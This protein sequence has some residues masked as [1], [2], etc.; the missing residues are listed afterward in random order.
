MS[1][2]KITRPLAAASLACVLILSGCGAATHTVWR[3]QSTSPDGQW[4]AGAKTEQT[5]GPGNAAIYTSVYLKR[6]QGSAA[7][8]SVLLFRNEL[9]KESGKI[10]L[11]LLWAAPDQLEVLV[12]KLPTFDTQV[13]RYAG[14]DISVVLAVLDSPAPPSADQIERALNGTDLTAARRLMLD[15]HCAPH[16]TDQVS[17]VRQAWHELG[18][19]T[20]TEVTQVP[21]IQALMAQ[22]LIQ[23]LPP[24][25]PPNPDTDSALALLRSAVRSDDILEA[26]AAAEGLIHYG[27]PRDNQSV[28]AIIH[29]DPKAT[30]F[31]STALRHNCS[32]NAAATLQLLRDQATD[33][34]TKARIQSAIKR[35]ELERKEIC[36]ANH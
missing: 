7:E 17:A 31:L 9:T 22:C 30:T 26:V 3:T 18:S 28:V 8:E 10:D 35:T 13:T 36:D 1:A 12:S 4:I 33:P 5:S 29:R 20:S 6:A 32:P 34:V 2:G 23:S 21:L 25:P 15:L 14:I 27:D 16:M 11:A 19:T 24:N